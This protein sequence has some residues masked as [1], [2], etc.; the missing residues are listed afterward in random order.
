MKIYK[1][2]KNILTLILLVALTFAIFYFGSMYINKNKVPLDT[3]ENNETQIDIEKEKLQNK[4][5]TSKSFINEISKLDTVLFG[6]TNGEYTLTHDRT[7]NGSKWTEWLVD[8]NISLTVTYDAIYGIDKEYVTYFV[9][10]D[11]NCNI[12]YSEKFFEVASLDI[13]DINFAEQRSIL[14][15]EYSKE[16][17]LALRKIAKERITAE[18]LQED[19]KNA[20]T[21]KLDEYFYEQ[22]KNLGIE[23]LII[24]GVAV[25]L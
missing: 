1:K 22:A 12:D 24:N 14:G 23:K 6:K 3:T 4:I 7:P 17:L 5:N 16:D 13:K 21:L 11:G 20:L 9:D 2:L 8:S 19:K 15:V 18:L 25:E 10:K